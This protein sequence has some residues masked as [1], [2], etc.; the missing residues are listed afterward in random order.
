MK[1]VTVT[2][3]GRD[4]VIKELPSR[5]ASAWRRELAKV[6]TPLLGLVEKAGEGVEISNSQDIMLLVRQVAP[7]IAESPDIVVDLLC[8]YAGT[9]EIDLDEVY[10][11]EIMD[12]FVAVLGLAY[13]FASLGNYLR[14]AS[15]SVVEPGA[16]ISTNSQSQNGA[17]QGATSTKFPA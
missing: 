4:M 8:S 13:P 14:R 2:L 12:A 17:T 3:A 11:S 7:L 15:G 5:K 16:R 1:S 10:D 6:L 9:T